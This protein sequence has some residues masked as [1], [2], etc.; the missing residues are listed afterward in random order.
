MVFVKEAY[1]VELLQVRL[2]RYEGKFSLYYAGPPKNCFYM[3]YCTLCSEK[4][5]HS[6]FLSYLCGKRLDLHK[7][8]GECLAGNKY[9]VGGKVRYSLL[10][11]MSS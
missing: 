3:L 10:P 2:L 11:A 4:N 1:F 5:T 6:R 7:I 8:L 9:S